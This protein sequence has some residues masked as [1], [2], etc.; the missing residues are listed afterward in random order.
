M[1]I[2]PIK[3]HITQG[4]LDGKTPIQRNDTKSPVPAVPWPV[5]DRVKTD[6]FR[7]WGKTLEQLEKA[8]GITLTELFCL[9][10]KIDPLDTTKHGKLP[11]L[12]QMRDWARKLK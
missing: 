12:D 7:I 6:V 1:R 11:T 2:F 5:I 3:D 8:E 10:N 4:L 9:Y